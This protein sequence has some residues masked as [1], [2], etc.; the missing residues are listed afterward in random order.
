V[1]NNIHDNV[2]NQPPIRKTEQESL[3]DTYIIKRLE[4]ARLLSD[5]FKL[6]LIEQFYT[7]T[8][9][10]QVADKLGEKAPRLYRHV[11]AMVDAGL[12]VLVEEKP[13]RGTVERYYKSVAGRFEMDPDLFN[14]S[15]EAADSTFA[16]VRAALKETE[17][18][19]AAI[20]ARVTRE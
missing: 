16:L 19:L 17:S 6:R 9:T 4:Q 2:N 20:S 13:K 15:G 5:P 11:D 8:T 1:N 18:E 10:K 12:L 7:P 14:T 3:L